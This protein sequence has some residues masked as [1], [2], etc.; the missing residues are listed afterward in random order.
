M[1]D[2]DE[3]IAAAMAERRRCTRCGDVLRRDGH[4]IGAWLSAGVPLPGIG[5]DGERPG[6]CRAGNDPLGSAHV[7]GEPLAVCA[8]CGH[9]APAGEMKPELTFTWRPTGGTVCRDADECFKRWYAKDRPGT[10]QPREAG[11]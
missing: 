7:P 4:L 5:E 6:T 1:G 10:A 11:K 8:S 2:W 9:A 3:E